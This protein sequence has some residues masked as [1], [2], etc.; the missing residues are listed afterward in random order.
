MRMENFPFGCKT[1]LDPS[2]WIIFHS[3]VKIKAQNKF[4]IRPL[5]DQNKQNWGT[6][7]AKN[8]AFAVCIR[9]LR[10]VLHDVDTYPAKIIRSIYPWEISNT[11][12]D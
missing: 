6:A 1:G 10:A 3:N 5:H 4:C 7:N 11:Q 9:P 2:E 12:L 8:F